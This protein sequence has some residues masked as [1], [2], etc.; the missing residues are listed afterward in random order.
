MQ[1]DVLP[2]IDQGGLLSES[3]RRLMEKEMTEAEKKEKEDKERKMGRPP[4]RGRSRSRSPRQAEETKVVKRL[5]GSTKHQQCELHAIFS[6]EVRGG[7]SPEG[8]R[9]GRDPK[10]H[11]R[12]QD[13]QNASKRSA[14]PA[15]HPRR[16]AQLAHSFLQGG[17]TLFTYPPRPHESVSDALERAPRCSYPEDQA[18][19]AHCRGS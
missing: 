18:R 17:C 6:G 1:S 13:S 2:G 9:A 11:D 3:A 5:H 8:D 16:S 12:P 15:L 7:R 10:T 14:G 4:P 19:L